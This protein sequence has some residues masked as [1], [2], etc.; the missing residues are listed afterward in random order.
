MTPPNSPSAAPRAATSPSPLPGGG[1][2]RI[3]ARW[4]A[5][6]IVD[7]RLESRRP[8]AARLL[9]GKT[10]PEVLALVPRLFSLCG[11][12]QHAVAAAALAA[13]S[14]G[15]IAE[16]SEG[17][18]RLRR[19][20]IG[21]HLWRLCIDWPTRLQRAPKQAEFALWYRR[22]RSAEPAAELAAELQAATGPGW[23]VPLVEA[24]QPWER[25]LALAPRFLPALDA[26]L[27]GELFADPAPGFAAAPGFRGD[28]VEVGALARFAGA[29]E[30]ADLLHAGRPL[31]A[32]LYARWLALRAE[33]AALA[34][35]ESATPAAVAAPGGAG[36]AWA[37]T[38]RGPLCHRVVLQGGRV[39]DY[40]VIA[41]TEWN[42][43]PD[44][45]WAAALANTP[46]A[47]PQLAEQLL[48]LWALAL[49]P[50]VP[51]QLTL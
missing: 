34:A 30:V 25:R 5:G 20:A 13:A 37:E 43:H 48:L 51:V 49:D 21:E 44:S 47:T 45:T 26:A 42:F 23:L 24:L 27:A 3:V 4:R 12:A 28:A 14:G 22:L 41:P 32:R 39:A 8:E 40:A 11:Q 38:S 16:G 50:C 15:A 33:L 36:Y 7:C 9:R 19:E 17:G 31:A 29:P 18:Q 6:C 46:A 35:G 10:A 2:V 1:A